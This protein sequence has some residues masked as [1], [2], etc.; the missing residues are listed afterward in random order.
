MTYRTIMTATIVVLS[1]GFGLN[2]CGGSSGDNTAVTPP[3]PPPPP[4]PPGV[5]IATQ[6]VFLNL[7]AFT[8][9]L[10]ML[11][12]PGDASR[13]Y[14]VQRG[15]QVLSF[16]NDPDANG[17]DPFIDVS[18]LQ[19]FDAG[20]AEA[21]LLGMVFHPDYQNNREVFLSFTRAG[22]ISHVSRFNSNDNGATLDPG[23]EEMIL[24][25]IQDGP[26]HN[27]GTVVFGPDGFLYAGFGDG[28]GSNDANDNAQNTANLLG[29]IV[30][31]DVDGANPYA[32]PGDNPFAANAGSLCVQGNGS[33]DCPE[34]FAWG[35]RN[36]WRFSFDRDGGQLWAGDVG[37]GM[38]EEVDRIDLGG[39]Y[40]WRIREGAHCNEAIDPNCIAVGLI[41]PVTEYDHTVGFSI[42]GGFSYRGGSIP[43][44]IGSFLYGDFSTGRIWGV[45]DD[46]QG[47]DTGVELLDTDIAI[48][49]FGEAD[50]GELYL[51]DYNAG[52]LHQIVEQ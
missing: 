15:G 20:P 21:G 44:L 14:V 37:Q 9:P 45:F 3:P 40:G 39:N 27:G 13:W 36:P 2:G 19:G 6:A 28:G 10:L 11:Q 8:Q 49:S 30:R 50:N 4:P 32:I 17:T 29:S 38:W 41:D 42:T 12:A 47:S 51:V 18:M 23:S 52:T 25:V 16:D 1:L 48:S 43:G 46:G 33:A 34:I 35:L 7:P 22:L 24:T 26:N 5:A 31:I